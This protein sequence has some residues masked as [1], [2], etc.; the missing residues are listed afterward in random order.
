MFK[1]SLRNIWSRKGRLLLTATAVIAGT[2]FL[3]GVFVFTDTIKGSFDQMFASAYAKTDAF[4][5]SNNVVEGDFG[6][7]IRDRI[8]VSLVDAVLKVPGVVEAH[9]DV[10][11]SA[12]VTTK[13]GKVI[14]QDGPPKFAGAWIDSEGSPWRLDSGHAPSS[15]TE[16]VVDK[17]SATLG[18]LHLGDEVTVTS[19]GKPRQFTVVGIAKFA[20]K[21]TSGG[22]TWTL[23]T[24]PT[25]QEF[26]IGDTTKIDN[27]VV[28]GDGSQTQQEVATSINAALADP[29][30]EVLTGQQII[31]ENQ[32]AVEK[33]LSFITIFLSIFALISLFVGSF[34]IY[35]VFSI[36]AAQRTRENALLRAVGASRSQ[37]TRSM[38]IEAIVVGLGG[39]LLGCAGGVGLAWFILWAMNKAGIGPGQSTLVIHPTGFVVTL[40]VGVLVTIVCAIAPAIRSGRVP[41]LA[42]MRDVAID[43]ADVSRTRKVVGTLAVVSA[44]LFVWLG[45]RG[46]TM[47]LGGAASAL[48]LALIALGPFLATPV[49]RLATPVLTKLRGASGTMAGRNAARNPKRTA[50]TAGALAVGLALLIG[51][52][53]LGASA[54]ATTH[55]VVGKSF[56]GDYVVTAKQGNN[57]AS[58]PASLADDLKAAQVG[59]VMGLA[60]TALQIQEKVDYRAKQVIALRPADA[61]NV[62]DI[63]FVAGSFADLA[64]DGILVSKTKADRDALSVG[65]VVQARTIDGID[66]KLTVQGIFDTK[67]FGNLIVD[68]AIFDG[69][70]VPVFDIGVF[71]RTPGGVTAANSAAIAAV[72]DT[73]PSLK[74]QSRD[75]Y[76][77]DQSKQ[78][79]GF[80][81]FIYALL[82]MS[83]FIAIIGIVITLML[84]VYE[85]RRELGLLRAVGTTRR[86]VRSAVLWESMVTAVVGVIAGTVLGVM[87]GWIIVAALKDQGLSVFSLPISTIVVAGALA[88]VFAAGAAVFP[89]RRAAKADILEAIA[90]T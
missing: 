56:N 19:Q 80:L 68:R 38:F 71:I 25:A 2:A 63:P 11:G 65:D 67:L 64:K 17:S 52:A 43:H 82:G 27:I 5:R 75:E 41:P 84:A 40:I 77:A 32:S 85:R 18:P 21:A 37:V 47:A 61:Q 10:Q 88:L 70:P 59:D 51:V 15:P 8:D 1:L 81:N 54:K 34:I 29:E 69:S 4:V 48:F 36:S 66:L 6:Q 23:F 76:I 57:G 9:G 31:S 45:L 16:V 22:A 62:L 73:Y 46:N 35:N 28:R 24:L 7:D 58:V 83:I 89:A 44:A 55:D 78:I 13:D 20:G 30:V 12:T 87:L 86:Q 26:V 3:S 79:D 53:T 50:L 90:T 72:V 39:S 33:T 42:A 74:L 60:A 14:G 49:A